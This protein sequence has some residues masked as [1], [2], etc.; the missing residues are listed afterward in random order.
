MM[1]LDRDSLLSSSL[2]DVARLAIYLGVFRYGMGKRSAID[3]ILEKVK[4]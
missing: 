2:V 3:A 4:S 1:K